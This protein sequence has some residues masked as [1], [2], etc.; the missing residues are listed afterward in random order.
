M[1]G[2]LA[3]TGD[4]EVPVVSLNLTINYD[5]TSARGE[6]PPNDMIQVDSCTADCS[7]TGCE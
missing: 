2:S 3:V 6:P 4:E 5:P 1:T 7:A